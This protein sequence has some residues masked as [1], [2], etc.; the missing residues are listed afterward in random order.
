MLT[1]SRPKHDGPDRQ[2]VA[3]PIPPCT[4]W[5]TNS[6]A[7]L[8]S[9]S[10]SHTRDRLLPLCYVDLSAAPRSPQPDRRP[11]SETDRARQSRI[12]CIGTGVALF[13]RPRELPPCGVG[14]FS[15]GGR[16]TEGCIFYPRVRGGTL[17]PTIFSLSPIHQARSKNASF[18]KC[19][20]RI[21]RG[22]LIFNP[23][24]SY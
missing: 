14:F 23:F 11:A 22:I 1:V 4:N 16:S 19:N 3:N 7:F 24:F 2:P 12:F 21:L 8:Y 5:L 18:V 15:A 9:V 6:E 10:F 13:F 17:A 20:V